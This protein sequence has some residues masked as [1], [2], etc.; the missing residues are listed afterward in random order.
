MNEKERGRIKL[1]E[2]V[3]NDTNKIT[4]GN[5][6]KLFCG[7]VSNYCDMTATGKKVKEKLTA[8]EY[9]AFITGMCNSLLSSLYASAAKTVKEQ[10]ERKEYVRN[11]NSDLLVTEKDLGELKN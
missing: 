1:L 4:V 7:L 9:V 8:D 2:K 5:A 3:T 6:A 11:V 10:K